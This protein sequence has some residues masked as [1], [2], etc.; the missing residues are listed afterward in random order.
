MK[1]GGEKRV[2]DDSAVKKQALRK[3]K[4][5]IQTFWRRGSVRSLMETQTAP[6]AAAMPAGKPSASPAPS[7]V[8]PTPMATDRP[9]S[10]WARN[11]ARDT[12]RGKVTI[13]F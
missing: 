11:T 5:M 4:P 1:T 13:L 2:K 8:T 6:V 3:A 10:I 12:E 7:P 9:F